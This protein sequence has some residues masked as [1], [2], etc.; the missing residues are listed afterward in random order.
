[1]RVI[2][3][4]G[5]LTELVTA[6]PVLYLRYSSGPEADAAHPSQDYE[7]GV[8]L[9]GLPVTPLR[10]EAWWTRPPHEWVARRVCKYL[11]LAQGPGER[12]AWVLTGPVVGTGPDHEPLIGDPVPVA[13]LGDRL[14]ER[15]QALYEERFDVGKSSR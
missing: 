1:M 14:I 4:L 8:D 7:A 15:A 6:E 2:D 13:R 3:D 5:E 12:F 9:P 11:N 10:P